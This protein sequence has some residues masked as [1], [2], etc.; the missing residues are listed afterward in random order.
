MWIIVLE[1]DTQSHNLMAEEQRGR[2]RCRHIEGVCCILVLCWESGCKVGKG[3]FKD[4]E[5]S[6]R[7]LEQTTT[8]DITYPGCQGHLN[9]K[10]KTHHNQRNITF[11]MA[12][13]P[14]GVEL[15]S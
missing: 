5:M 8:P 7:E 2:Q 13:I 4:K 9:N 12:T 6:S 14:L 3:H 11:F 10:D 1:E 15:L